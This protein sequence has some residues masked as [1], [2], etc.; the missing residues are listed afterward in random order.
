MAAGTKAVANAAAQRIVLI[1]SG[2][3][4]E[5]K[6]WEATADLMLGASFFW[7]LTSGVR[8]G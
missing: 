2:L 7:L 6:E 8:T 4:F 1:M 5:K 3:L